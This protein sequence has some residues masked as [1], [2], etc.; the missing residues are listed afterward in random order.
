MEENT[1]EINLD[2][3]QIINDNLSCSIIVANLRRPFTNIELK[4]KLEGFGKVDYFWINQIK[5]HCFV[6]YSDCEESNKALEG[7]NMTVWPQG[8]RKLVTSFVKTEDLEQ[9]TK[10]NA[11]PEFI[12]STVNKVNEGLDVPLKKIKMKRVNG[13]MVKVRY[14][15][16]LI[17]EDPGM[18]KKK[19]TSVVDQ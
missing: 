18:P 12:A 17:S 3:S 11:Y 15:L 16:K 10:T 6:T 7:L 8:G 2:N 4:E 9:L 14:N 5:T 19:E 13:K 1:S